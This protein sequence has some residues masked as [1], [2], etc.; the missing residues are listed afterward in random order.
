M[1]HQVAKIKKFDHTKYCEN[2]EQLEVLYIANR[3]VKVTLENSLIVS[4]YFCV[5]IEEQW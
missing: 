2:I 4:F 5:F 1:Y 3:N